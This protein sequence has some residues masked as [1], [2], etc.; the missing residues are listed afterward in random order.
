MEQEEKLL[1]YL[2]SLG[3]TGEKLESDVRENM[4]T[5]ELSFRISHTRK[6]GSETMS[7]ELYF[8]KTHQF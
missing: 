2:A 8:G 1:E 3:F 5:G 4:K 7:Y 6:F